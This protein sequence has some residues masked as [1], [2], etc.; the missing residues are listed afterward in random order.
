MKIT[1]SRTTELSSSGDLVLRSE[2]VLDLDELTTSERESDAFPR[3]V[4]SFLDCSADRQ[5]VAMSRLGEI[6]GSALCVAVTIPEGSISL[7]ELDAIA[8]LAP[9]E[10]DLELL[11]GAI[12]EQAKRNQQRPRT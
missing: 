11:E 4:A 9:S 12:T 10:Q 3:I 6:A 1:I 2:D 7:D 8:K 5:K